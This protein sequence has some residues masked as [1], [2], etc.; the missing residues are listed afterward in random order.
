MMNEKGML[1][2]KAKLKLKGYESRYCYCVKKVGKHKIP[3]FYFLPHI[4]GMSQSKVCGTNW[5]TQHFSRIIN[6]LYNHY[7]QCNSYICKYAS[8]V[9]ITS[10]LQPHIV[11]VYFQIQIG[12]AAIPPCSSSLS[13]FTTNCLMRPCVAI[14][15][16]QLMHLNVLNAKLGWKIS[17]L[18]VL[19]R[20]KFSPDLKQM[21]IILSQSRWWLYSETL[22]DIQPKIED[23][24]GREND[25]IMG[26]GKCGH[27]LASVSNTGNTWTTHSSW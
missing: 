10:L 20:Y 24:I 8:W 17:K 23:I 9:Y 14:W 25:V 27:Q 26:F 22:T 12:T 18:N 6:V 1:K 4:S 15:A 16:T 19:A 11:N 7:A 5:S 3:L 13:S 21:K 2:L